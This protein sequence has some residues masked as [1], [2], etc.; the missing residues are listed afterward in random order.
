[1]T[2]PGQDGGGPEARA[3]DVVVP[4]HDQRALVEDC[5]RSV[6]AARN[7]VASEVVVVDDGSTDA[8]L[9]GHLEALARDGR[10]TLLT[11]ERN[12]GF[13]KSV[14]RGMKLHPDRDV[15]LLNSDTVVH[16][17]WLDRLRRAA[18][19]APMIGTAN[20][21]T[22]ASHIGCYP[23]RTADGAVTFEVSDAELDAMAAEAN[24]GRSARVHTTVGFCM[25]IRRGCLRAVGYF[26]DVHFPY[27]Y[28]EESDFCYRAGKL[29]WRH[30]V[31]GDVFVRH[32]EGQSFGE[33]KARMVAE[34][35]SVFQRLHPE[36][37]AKDRD[38]AARDPIRPLR[39]ALDLARVRRLL[40]GRSALPCVPAT[41]QAGDTEEVRLLFDRDAGSVALGARGGQFL[42]LE[43]WRLPA[44]VVAFN[45]AMRFL[46]VTELVFASE[47]AR[48]AV[49]AMT[50][51]LPVEV[52]PAVSLAVAPRA[53]SMAAA[54]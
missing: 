33:R 31:T 45:R 27:G 13:T 48:Q 4:V 10:I 54:A 37:A 53:A 6:L 7:A 21:L 42:N 52:V 8:G 44:D 20:P 46:G 35:I 25:Y 5:L 15:V 26:D 39:A 14:N 1:M 24:A 49:E 12:L 18:H 43:T 23:A 11:N 47:S 22:N 16:G 28:G 51:G 2:P 41:Q 9:K 38:F 3:V 34:M 50:H 36:L 30:V 32:W 40:D 19:A 17:D 29:G